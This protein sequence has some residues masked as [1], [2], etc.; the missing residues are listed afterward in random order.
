MYIDN[1]RSDENYYIE[2]PE[3]LPEELKNNIITSSGGEIV[4]MWGRGFSQGNGWQKLDVI[5]YDKLLCELSYDG[6]SLKMLTDGTYMVKMAAGGQM[7]GVRLLVNNEVIHQSG[8]VTTNC[9]NVMQSGLYEQTLIKDDSIY[10]E[11]VGPSNWACYGMAILFKMSD[12][13]EIIE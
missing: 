7:G 11:V 5:L 2:H 4:A 9:F 8:D 10:S 6:K 1:L 3:L 12:N 13:Y